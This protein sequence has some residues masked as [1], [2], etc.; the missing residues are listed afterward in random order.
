MAHR[1][2]HKQWITFTHQ[3]TQGAV[4]AFAKVMLF[5]PFATSQEGI[6]GAQACYSYTADGKLQFPGNYREWVCL[7]YGSGMTYGPSANPN[8]PP[9]FDSVF[10]NPAA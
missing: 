1:Q 3:L 9:Q 6:R 4:A 8:G 2:V 5:P 10:V 7:S